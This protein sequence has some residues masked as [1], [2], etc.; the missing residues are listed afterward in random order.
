MSM[1]TER[2]IE[3]YKNARRQNKSIEASLLEAGYTLKTARHRNGIC[4]LAIIGEQQ[5]AEEFDKSKVTVESVLK[6]LYEDRRLAEAKHDI[7]TMTRVDELIGKYLAMF[8]DKQQ[9]HSEVINKTEKDIL[10]KYISG[11]R[12]P[13]ELINTATENTSATS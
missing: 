9:I 7:A 5:L 10:N 3:Q 8:T 6:N 12:M 4:K 2:Q 11:N 1:Y 13:T